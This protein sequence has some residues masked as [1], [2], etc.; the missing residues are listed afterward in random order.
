VAQLTRVYQTLAGQNQSLDKMLR[1]SV[2]DL[3]T[4]QAELK[5]GM[6]AAEFNLRAHQKAINSMALEIARMKD[7]MLALLPESPTKAELQQP[8]LEMADVT[9]PPD[10]EGGEPQVVQ[11]VNWPYY[12]EQVE[13]DLK[14][15]AELEEQRLA[16]EKAAQE[17][18]AARK[19]EEEVSQKEADIEA[20]MVIGAEEGDEDLPQELAEGEAKEEP[21]GAPPD[22]DGIPEGA[23]VF[24]G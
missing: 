14:I 3:Y 9:L 15:L 24:G 22:D 7:F 20:E 23:T 18:E 6:S 16:E 10:E 8:I 12:H 21:Q 13:K 5:Q 17:A 2:T 11:R 19:A 1:S 4:N